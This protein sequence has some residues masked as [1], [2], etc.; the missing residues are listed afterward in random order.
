MN[1]QPWVWVESLPCYFLWDRPFVQ[2]AEDLR[3]LPNAYVEFVVVAAVVAV[4]VDVVDA[5][6]VVADE[7]DAADVETLNVVDVVAVEHDGRDQ[8]AE[9]GSC[10]VTTSRQLVVLSGR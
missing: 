7:V 3:V 8:D 2:A 5:D 6:A 1:Y 4:A 10:K 9:L